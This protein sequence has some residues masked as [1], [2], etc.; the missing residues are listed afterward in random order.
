MVSGLAALKI[1]V[2]VSFIPFFHSVAF[3]VSHTSKYIFLSRDEPSE[4][5]GGVLFRGINADKAVQSGVKDDSGHFFI[6]VSRA[7]CDRP[8]ARAACGKGMLRTCPGSPK[9]VGVVDVARAAPINPINPINPGLNPA[10]H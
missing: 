9:G 10:A 3:G 2:S 6:S 5:S 8:G 4:G 7:G 1:L